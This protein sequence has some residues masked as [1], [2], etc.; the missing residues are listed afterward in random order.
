[1]ER[2]VGRWAR[3]L[4]LQQQV[5]CQ[6]QWTKGLISWLPSLR[7]HLECGSPFP[8]SSWL[9]DCILAFLWP[10]GLVGSQGGLGSDTPAFESRPGHPLADEGV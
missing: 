7:C 6:A 3:S 9:N 1:M 4:S 2:P 10:P 8:Q 5:E